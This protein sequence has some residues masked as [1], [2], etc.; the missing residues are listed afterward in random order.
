MPRRTVARY[1]PDP[2]DKHVGSRIRLKRTLLGLSQ[3]TVA[4]TLGL[5]FQQ[6]QKYESGTN[7]V[8]ASK[9]FHLAASLGVDPNFFFEGLS[10]SGE[11]VTLDAAP[12]MTRTMLEIAK[13]LSGLPPEVIAS[14]ATS[15]RLLSKAF[16]A[17]RT[18]AS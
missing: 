3:T 17:A 12:D 14:T 11:P 13:N 6:L 18:P 2:I 9:L 8:S 5:T 1:G 7:R 4:E 10:N 16:K 15:I